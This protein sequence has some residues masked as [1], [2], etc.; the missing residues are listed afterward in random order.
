MAKV[1]ITLEDLPQGGVKITSEPLAGLLMQKVATDHD[2][3][4][5]EGYAVQ[6]LNEIRKVSKKQ[7]NKFGLLL[8][9]VRQ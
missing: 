3:S 9:R 5:A 8:P 7:G 1:V 2:I 4:P 6:A